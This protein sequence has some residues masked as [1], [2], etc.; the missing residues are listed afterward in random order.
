MKRIIVRVDSAIK[1]TE[2]GGHPTVLYIQSMNT[3]CLKKLECRYPSPIARP[4]VQ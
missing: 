4:P 2:H 1:N 3:V